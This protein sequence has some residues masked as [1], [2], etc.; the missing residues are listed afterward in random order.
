[1]QEHEIV[2]RAHDLRID[3]MFENIRRAVGFTFLTD[4]EKAALLR[5]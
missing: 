3:Q 1:L 2:Q 5:R 4:D